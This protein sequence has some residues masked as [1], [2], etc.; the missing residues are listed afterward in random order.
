MWALALTH[1][2]IH[3]Q[4]YIYNVH[5]LGTMGE[6]KDHVVGGKNI[7]NDIL[8]QYKDESRMRTKQQHDNYLYVYF[9]YICILCGS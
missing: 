8:K 9:L 6:D 1:L 7:W 5:I 4:I 3:I 2:H